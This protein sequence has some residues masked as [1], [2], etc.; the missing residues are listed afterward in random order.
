MINDV[1]QAYFY[2]KAS[3]H[4]FVEIPDEDPR[5]KPGL[6]GRLKL[7]L[8]GTRDAA[9]SWQKTLTEHLLK[10]GFKRGRGHISVFHHP[11]RGI[12]TLVIAAQEHEQ[13]SIGCR[14]S[15]RKLMN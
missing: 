9:K 7:C 3:R 14:P 10:I 1:R 4:L 11:E 6:V 13:T 12:K 5:K 15:W 2:A 8:Y